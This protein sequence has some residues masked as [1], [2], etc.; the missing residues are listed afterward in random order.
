MFFD[1][2]IVQ[3]DRSVRVLT[4]TV[5]AARP[6]PKPENGTLRAALSTRDGRRAAALMRVNHAGEICAQALYQAQYCATRSAFL[7][8]LLERAAREEEDHLNWTLKRLE[9][10]G[11]RPS[12]LSPLWYGGAFT[13]GWLAGKAGDRASLGFM[14]E[15]E[16]QVTQHLERQLARLPVDDAASRAILEQMRLDEMGHAHAAHHA[17]AIKLPRPVRDLMRAAARMMTRTA[18]YI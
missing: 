6:I 12:W 11:A 7:K 18:Y 17:G 13:I 5:R 2:L 15:T 4:G 14:A 3:L 9:A 16:R 8:P 10:L 1:R